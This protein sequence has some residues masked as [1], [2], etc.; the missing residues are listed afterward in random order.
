MNKKEFI[1]ILEDKLSILNV[2][3][4]QDIIDEYK[5]IINEKVKHGKTEEEA[6]ADFGD[7]D[8]LIEGILSAYKINPEYYQ[9]DKDAGREF[10]KSG[11]T[12][13]KRFA[14]KLA[15]FSRH[16]FD[17]FKNNTNGITVELIFE[18]LIK[19]VIFLFIMAIIK[20]PFYLIHELGEGILEF[21]LAPI[22]SILGFIWK[23][24]VGIIYLVVCIL[25]GIA[26]FSK[27]FARESEEEVKDIINDEK[28]DK[29]VKT[30]KVV[31]AEAQT[32]QK[33]KCDSKEKGESPIVNA[34]ILMAKIF[35]LVTFLLP[36]LG[37]SI[38]GILAFSTTI[39]LLIKGYDVWGICLLALGGTAIV[40]NIFYILWQLLF[41]HKKLHFYPSVI[42]LVITIVGLF[43][44]FDMVSKY[45]FYDRVPEG[46]YQESVKRF[47][48][49]IEQPTVI[50]DYSDDL[51]V[52]IDNNIEDNKA[53]IEVYYYKDLIDVSLRKDTFNE[54]YNEYAI[55]YHSTNFNRQ[56]LDNILSDLKDYKIYNYNK[57][58]DYRTKVYVNEKTKSLIK[59]EYEFY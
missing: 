31:K 32:K 7:L 37:I 20:I 16:V 43:M 19:I 11:E 36:M 33:V 18:I 48:E 1:N 41:G 51:E 15:D 58:N 46:M 21:N 6:I 2:L 34:L 26:M 54:G 35:L 44:T 17:N 53:I 25:I 30:K 49:K 14:N 42:G 8:E 29:A 24:I 55:V 50:E 23:A 5:D 13:I 59:K 9:T 47:E 4:R 39:Y 27:Y 12:L 57:L 22:D 52:I 45:E 28:E 38:S 10:I 40:A 3:E 56:I